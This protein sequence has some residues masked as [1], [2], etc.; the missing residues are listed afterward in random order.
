[1]GITY[2]AP[3]IASQALAKCVF[4][5]SAV[6]TNIDTFPVPFLDLDL[7]LEHSLPEPK[8]SSVTN[9]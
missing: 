1:M 7:D 3:P 2:I 9:R 4:V 6:S 8:G 5:Q